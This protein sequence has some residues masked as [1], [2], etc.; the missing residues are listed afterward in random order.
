MDF[1][2]FGTFSFFFRLFVAQ[3]FTIPATSM[4]PTLELDDY[5]WASKFSYGYSNFSM[6]YGELLPVLTFAKRA[7]KRG[8]VVVFRLPSDPSVD[9]LKRV[10]G[11]PGDTVQVKA[12]VTYLNG[13][14]LKRS[15]AGSYKIAMGPGSHALEGW[16]FIETLPEGRSYA[17]VEVEEQSMGDDTPVF[18]VPAGH[19]FVMG[20]NRDNSSDS[21]FTV[22]F[23]PEANIIAKVL[24]AITWPDGKF[25]KREV[26]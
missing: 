2:L 4:A 26:K 22:G 7:P 12:G 21:R 25:T 10:I 15:P 18:A 11:L 17:I 8:D 9:Y 23:V 13:K 16:K 6:P 5:V 24:V 3:P 20:D 14:P 1:V 19:Y